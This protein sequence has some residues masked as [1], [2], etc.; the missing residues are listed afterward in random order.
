MQRRRRCQIRQQCNILASIRGQGHCYSLEAFV[1]TSASAAPALLLSFTFPNPREKRQRTRTGRGPDAGRTI[2]FEETDADR[3]RTGRGRGRFS[4]DTSGGGILSV[5][6]PEDL[7]LIF[8]NK[9][10]IFGPP[11]GDGGKKPRPQILIHIGVQDTG[12]LDVLGCAIK[13]DV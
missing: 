5:P 2:E 4:Q 10:D 13:V 1:R 6:R 7:S 9:N 8:P 11:Y 3:T 12:T